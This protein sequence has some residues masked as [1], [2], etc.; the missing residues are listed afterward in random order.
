MRY[1]LW[2]SEF[3]EFL[4]ER[5]KNR[6]NNIDSA[7]N[8]IQSS[9]N[10]NITYNNAYVDVLTFEFGYVSNIINICRTNNGIDT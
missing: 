4:T 6:N 9:L 8:I 5:K 2:C 7:P 3:L 1:I 10:N